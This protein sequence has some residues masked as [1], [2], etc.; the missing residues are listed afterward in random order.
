MTP[1]NYISINEFENQIT[2]ILSLIQN[3]KYFIITEN[4]KPVAKVT[5]VNY[6]KRIAGL[7]KGDLEYISP[8]FDVNLI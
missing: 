7:N 8:D 3:G 1:S 2:H 4:N 6:S 5:P